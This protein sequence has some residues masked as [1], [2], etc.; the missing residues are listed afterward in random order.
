MENLL[1][2]L[3]TLLGAHQQAGQQALAASKA[4]PRQQAQPQQ[5]GGPS[6][7]PQ[8]IH[9]AQLLHPLVMAHLQAQ[10][11]Q[12]SMP[13]VP[14]PNGYIPQGAPITPYARINQPIAPGQNLQ[15]GPGSSALLQP[16]GVNPQV[17]V[18]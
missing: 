11:P 18:M 17:G 8:L 5:Y 3:T 4:Q 14:V 6:V 13:G 9:F 10:L 12:P 16:G 1:H 7:N 15:P 2:A